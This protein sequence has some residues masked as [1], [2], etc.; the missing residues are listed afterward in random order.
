[1]LRSLPVPNPQELRI[2]GWSGAG[3]EKWADNKMARMGPVD[4]GNRFLGDS[5]SLQGFHA[6]RE[7]C[8]AQADVFGY[9]PIYHGTTFRARHAAVWKEGLMVSDNFFSGLGVRPLIGRLFDANDER[10]EGMPAVV[11]SYRLWEQQFGLDPNALGQ[12]VM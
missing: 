2:I 6:L 1:M 5:V 3:W 4:S 10:A 8:A 9:F 12:S 7:Q 11:I